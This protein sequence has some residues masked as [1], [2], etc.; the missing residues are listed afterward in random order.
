MPRLG[1]AWR[2]SASG[3]NRG[4]QP[5]PAVPD[6][7]A[8]SR[9]RSGSYASSGS[10]G[11]GGEKGEKNR[12]N[13]FAMLDDEDDGTGAGGGG[14]GG[15][16]HP[17]SHGPSGNNGNPGGGVGGGGGGRFSALRPDNHTAGSAIGT[18]SSSR[19]FHRA[20]SSGSKPSK[21]GRSLADLAAGLSGGSGGGNNNNGPH[22][23]GGPHSQHH[24]G[25]DPRGHHGGQGHGVDPRGHPRSSSAGISRNR[26]GSGDAP[27]GHG[28]GAMGSI[29]GVVG[30]ESGDGGG[31]KVIRYTREK[32]LSL[33]GRG[34][35]GPPECIKELELEG[36]VVVSKV[37]QDPV[38]W[39]TFD[40]E[41]IWAAAARERRPADLREGRPKGGGHSSAGRMRDFDSGDE[42]ERPRGSIGA[43]GSGTPTERFSGTPTERFGGG[44][45]GFGDRGS[46]ADRGSSGGG[47]VDR[48]SMGDRGP[49]GDRGSSSGGFGGGR[50]QRGV[51]LPEG[52]VRP[53][54]RGRAPDS[55]RGLGRRDD[56]NLEASD[57]DDLWDDPTAGVTGGGTGAAADF[58]AFGGSLDDEPPQLKGK[59]G[60]DAFDL[61]DMSKAAA[62]FENELHGGGGHRKM[63]VDV[64]VNGGLESVGDN[65][66]SG[67]GGL[68]NGGNSVL[69]HNIDPTRPLASTGT[70]IRS[71]SGDHV[72]VF[73]D[74]GDE[75]GGEDAA[76]AIGADSVGGEEDNDLPIKSGNGENNASSRLMKMIGV[77]GTGEAASGGSGGGGGDSS[78]LPVDVVE[79]EREDLNSE[80]ET[81]PRAD[82]V[83]SVPSNPWGAPASSSVSSNPWGDAPAAGGFAVQEGQAVKD[84][85]AAAAAQ[86]QAQAAQR[87][88]EEELLRQQQ[89]QLQRQQA[90]QQAAEEEEKKRWA[91]MQAKQ[92]AEMQAAAAQQLAQQ[93][94]QQRQQ[95][96]VKAQQNQVELVLIERI[97]NILENSWGRS[98]LNSILSTLHANDSRVIAILSTAEALR[99]LVA[100]HPQ[101]IQLGRDPTMGAEM[102][103]LRLTNSQW[104]AHQAQ[105]AQA[106]A[107]QQAKL[108]QEQELQRRQR[109]QQEEQARAQAAQ[110]EAI[111]RAQAA[112]R[113]AEER[114]KQEAAQAA[115]A[116]AQ[117]QTPLVITDAPWYYADP[118]GN[119][120]G[121]FGGEEMRQWLDAGYF[122][123]DLPISQS[124]GGPFRTLGSCFSDA[125]TAFQPT[126][127]TEDKAE[128]EAKARTEAEAKARA[129][130]EAKVR[131]EAEKAAQRE[132]AAAEEAAALMAAR[133]AA[134]LKAR[135]EAEERARAEAEAQAAMQ[136]EK[137]T[138]DRKHQ[139]AQ[140][141][142][143]LGLGAAGGG[144]SESD[145]VVVAGLS[146]SEPVE[147]Q[148]AASQP[149]P[150]PSK[151]SKK[152]QQQQQMQREPVVTNAP[153]PVAPERAPAAPVAWGG[154]VATKVSRKKSMSEIQQ[155]EAREA[156]RRAR[157]QGISLSSLSGGGGGRGGGGGNGGWANI[158]ASG[159]ST[160]WGGAVKVPV[161]AVVTPTPMVA[162]LSAQQRSAQAAWGGPAA[163]MAPAGSKQQQSKSSGANANKNAAVDN[164]GMNGRMSPTLES[165]CK[166]Q[167]QKLN[168]SDDLTLVSFCMTLTDKDEI[169]QY[170]TAYLGST[171]QVNGFA[172]EF[173]KRKGLGEN[174]RKEETW[175]SA[176]KGKRGKKKG[177]K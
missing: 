31:A 78:P 45:G 91:A 42:G 140:L 14:G 26:S 143:M 166:D 92:Q 22:S 104:Q 107:A 113:E 171:T 40:A 44:G 48:G 114:K 56:D 12:S 162:G 77:A 153:S 173:I 61:S 147:Q 101:R 80:Q 2:S 10:G 151:K 138:A 105:A 109:V 172:S 152:K 88:R 65:G 176:G 19:P 50:W 25:G 83:A 146:P 68:E 160:A 99:A 142:M 32:M 4:F 163:T 150:A 79:A 9:D 161:A 28:G 124:S 81:K 64:N 133:Q 72:N 100:R 97:S 7:R 84:A 69:E 5:P 121:P 155:E 170:L 16:R 175:E 116:Q 71:G 29:G 73:E 1:P 93:Q 54:S 135:A 13:P 118:Q 70:T 86:A 8:S 156:Q 90:Q 11:G 94:A 82:S 148:P 98:D 137:A 63:V 23:H 49:V 35:E 130:A 141:K 53:S 62:D 177:G 127:P 136:R 41:E 34:D 154:A 168:G 15:E 123:G 106:Q 126:Q 139:S 17:P 95:E 120:Q 46:I 128:A 145:D 66:D 119:I 18:S 39:D 76:A 103:A 37:A 43:R 33:R 132:K 159:G 131:A 59:T 58:S 6:E 174:G 52:D 164:F 87:Q 3:A 102:A 36:S 67:G 60:M 57:P 115:Q 75:S 169:R 112:Q 89:Q 38:C 110:Q 144:V 85:E 117:Q 149:A 27:L 21:G 20:A 122:K 158:A 55:D 129:E 24:H 111:A 30:G 165:W 96:Q 74:F 108:A 125:S 47:Y 157:E 167:M 51:A 134:E